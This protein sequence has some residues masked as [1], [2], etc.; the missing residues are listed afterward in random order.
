[1][2]AIAFSAHSGSNG[3]FFDPRSFDIVNNGETPDCAFSQPTRAENVRWMCVHEFQFQSRT[4]TFMF[5]SILQG[6]ERASERTSWTIS[7]RRT[8]SFRPGRF[9]A[10]LS[11]RRLRLRLASGSPGRPPRRRPAVAAV[12]VAVVS[13]DWKIKILIPMWSLWKISCKMI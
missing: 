6:S 2:N 5:A 13:K 12:A 7:Y 10:H 3:F 9:L 4:A 11:C 8:R 1:M